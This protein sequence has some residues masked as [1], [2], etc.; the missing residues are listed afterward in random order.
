MRRLLSKSSVEAVVHDEQL[1]SLMV[2]IKGLFSDPIRFQIRYVLRQLLMPEGS[3]GFGLERAYTTVAL[4][5]GL[6][7]RESFC[8]GS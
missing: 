4:L 6:L 7:V 8:V 5:Q 2:L 3:N 1:S